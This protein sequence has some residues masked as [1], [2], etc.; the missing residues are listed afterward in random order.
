MAVLA[1]RPRQ[2]NA[3]SSVCAVAASELILW[4][5]LSTWVHRL[6][7]AAACSA[8][9]S[10]PALLSAVMAVQAWPLETAFQVGSGIGVGVGVGVGM[11]NAWDGSTTNG[12]DAGFGVGAA[13][14]QPTT[15]TKAP[16]AKPARHLA[17][18]SQPFDA[19]GIPQG[20][21][22]IMPQPATGVACLRR[23]SRGRPNPTMPR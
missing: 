9:A 16:T 12:R 8:V 3:A 22:H 10:V 21:R 14:P 18:E 23:C 11:L 6:A 5:W 15:K 13:L 2:L 20:T 4:A 7:T 19:I 17:T 1:G